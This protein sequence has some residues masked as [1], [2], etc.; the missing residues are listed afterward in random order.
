MKIRTIVAAASM[1]ASSGIALGQSHYT[2]TPIPNGQ[3]PPLSAP[4][5]TGPSLEWN[6]I[7]GGGR[8]LAAGVFRLEG[9]VGQPD[10]GELSQGAFAISGGF[11]PGVE[12]SS[13]CY[14]NCD[15]STGNPVLTANDFQCF[16]NRYTA[17]DPWANCDGS[18][19]PPVLNINDFQCFLNKFAGGCTL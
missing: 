14:A 2:A 3:L 15:G 18:T 4:T 10:A 5:D 8:V 7:D 1:T 19:V 13:T 12:S 16:L 6:S 11:W 9:S 17:G